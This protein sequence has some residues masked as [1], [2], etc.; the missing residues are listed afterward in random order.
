LDEK[1]C[2]ASRMKKGANWLNMLGSIQR[3]LKRHALAG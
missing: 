1:H 2:P 3:V